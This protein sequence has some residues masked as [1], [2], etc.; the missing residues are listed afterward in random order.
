VPIVRLEGVGQMQKSSDPSA[1]NIVPEPSKLPLGPK[2]DGY[3][4]PPLGDNALFLLARCP[5]NI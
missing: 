5:I 4:L 3:A 1:C 2:L